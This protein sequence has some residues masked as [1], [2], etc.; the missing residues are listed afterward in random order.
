MRKLNKQ[1]L[2]AIAYVQNAL[3]FLFLDN[4]VKDKINSIHLYGSA[5]R[6]ELTKSSDIDVFIDTALENEATITGIA[7]AAFGRFYKSNDYNKWKLLKFS[8][9]ISVQV[10]KLIT[11]ELK[12][13]IIADGIILYSKKSEILPAKRSVLFIFQLPKQKR[14]YLHLTRLLYGRKEHGYKEHGFLKEVNGKKISSNII[15]VPQESIQK[16][17][18][19]FQKDSVNYSMKEIWINE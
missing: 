2:T 4:D 3:G 8:H 19:V 12:T 18:E 16:T 17:I 14:K 5:V 6:G 15:I 9:L 7:N 10:G 11:W 1:T 13:S